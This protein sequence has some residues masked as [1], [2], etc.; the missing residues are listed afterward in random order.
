VE[1]RTPQETMTGS[2]KTFLHSRQYNRALGL[3]TN[4]RTSWHTQ[5]STH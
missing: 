2:L 3:S 1:I 4:S 5:T